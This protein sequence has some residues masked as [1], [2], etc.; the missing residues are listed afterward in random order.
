MI[1][2]TIEPIMFCCF[3]TLTFNHLQKLVELN[4]LRKYL[5]EKNAMGGNSDSSKN[6]TG[7][8]MRTLDGVPPRCV[9][10]YRGVGNYTQVVLK[11]ALF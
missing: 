5:A 7:A 6:P 10:P 2:F 4:I 1:F 3:P 8:L 9:T 11:W